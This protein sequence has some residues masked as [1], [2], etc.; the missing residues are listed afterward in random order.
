[1]LIANNKPICLIGFP[2]STITQE[3]QHYMEQEFSGEIIVMSPDDFI[4]LD[5]KDQYQYGIA[6]TLDVPLRIRV[7]NIVESLNLDCI[8]YVHDSVVCYTKDI[9]SVIGRGSFVA[10]FSSILLGAKVG[11]HCVIETYCLVAHYSVLDTNVI[12]HSGTLIAGKT[13]VGKNSVFNFRSTA[14][15]ALQIGGDIEVGAAS[16][17]T[18]SIDVPG[19]YVGTPARRIGDR[20][21]VNFV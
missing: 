12:L 7:I 15:N 3:A 13:R 21:E 20:R 14:V 9:Q 19:Y 10:P 8:R 17:I 2:A 1:M 6:F 18:K 16:T 4:A 11:A 5:N